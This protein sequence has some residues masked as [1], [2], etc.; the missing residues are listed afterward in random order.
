M[1]PSIR[2]P[3]VSIRWWRRCKPSTASGLALV[4]AATD[5]TGFGLLGHLGEMQRNRSLRVVLDGLA[6]PA[7][8]QALAL[9]ESGQ[10]S[11]LAPANRRAWAQLDDGS[12]DLNLSGI[13]SGSPRHQALLELLVDPQTCGPL[14][15]S[16]TEDI[17]TVLLNDDDTTWTEI[18]WVTPR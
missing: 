12:V 17:A 6:I 4:H 14:L 11:T 3:P 16:V 18:G 10:A 2:W 1:Q 15:I 9:L 13:R 7:L 5:I 8:P